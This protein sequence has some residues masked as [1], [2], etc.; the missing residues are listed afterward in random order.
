MVS[1]RATNAREQRKPDMKIGISLPVRELGDDI[2]AIKAF[3]QAAEELGLNHLRVPEQ[4]IRPGSGALHEPLTMMTLIAGATSRIE[5]VPSV[6]ILPAR[7]TA[8]VA[9]QAASLDRLS[10]GRLRLGVGVGKDPAE[11]EALGA[12]FSNRGA[13]CEEQMTLLKRLWTEPSVRFEGR[14]HKISDAGINPLPIRQPIPMWIG[15]G[16]NPTQRI[17][18]RIGTLADGWFVLASP[19]AYPAIRD[20]IH[21]AAEAIGRSP[22]EI[23]AEAGVA[24][25]GP[26]EH[27]WKSRVAG[28]REIG[29]THLCLRTLGGGLA[30]DAHIAKMREAVADLP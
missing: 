22:A 17:R 20:D 19:E 10:G 25:V 4:I 24:V 21:R 5:L 16:E 23:G 15:A 11:Y 30:T 9:K 2:G 13:R 12:D 7:Q 1:I 27:E 28:W 3:A 18:R 26:R 8:L 14:W 6:L 29:L